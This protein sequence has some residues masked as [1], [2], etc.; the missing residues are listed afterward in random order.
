MQG[1]YAD[2]KVDP[3]LGPILEWKSPND[4]A[5]WLRE[6]ILT[7]DTFQLVQME[8]ARQWVESVSQAPEWGLEELDA[9]IIVDYVSLSRTEA[10]RK[11][12]DA[13]VVRLTEALAKP[14]ASTEAMHHTV[15]RASRNVTPSQRLSP[16][17]RQAANRLV[18]LGR[19]WPR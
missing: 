2:T 18:H 17:M 3:E 1:A 10:D 8:R 13:H 7:G 11:K 14:M 19:R 16:L 4:V 6:N 15:D 9:Q 5:D 12:M